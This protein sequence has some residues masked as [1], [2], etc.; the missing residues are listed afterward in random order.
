VGISLIHL[1]ENKR[2][3]FLLNYFQCT[4]KLNQYWKTTRLL[5]CNIGGLMALVFIMQRTAEVPA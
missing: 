2:F 5:R 4:G 3:I 1:L